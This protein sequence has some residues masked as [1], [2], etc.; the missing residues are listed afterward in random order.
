MELP[1]SVM[2][3]KISTQPKKART[4][5][6]HFKHFNGCYTGVKRELQEVSDRDQTVEGTRVQQVDVSLSIASTSGC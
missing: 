1:R 4:T 5:Q 2:F 3:V 6:D